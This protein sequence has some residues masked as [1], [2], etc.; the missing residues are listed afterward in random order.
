MT[1]RTE[2]DTDYKIGYGK[3]PL[4]TQFPKGKSGNPRGRTPKIEASR[5]K[6]QQQI[7][8]LEIAEEPITITV[9]GKLKR[10]SGFQA[11]VLKLRQKAIGGDIRSIMLFC[12]LYKELIGDFSEA[13]PEITSMIDTFHKGRVLQ[14][15]P[16]DA[17]AI[18]FLNKIHKK[19]RGR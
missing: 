2:K 17:E 5:S 12:A 13:N 10:V 7:E 8:F 11:V 9:N 19:T 4:H 15:D 14:P 1:D 6:R 3:P 18:K 16:L